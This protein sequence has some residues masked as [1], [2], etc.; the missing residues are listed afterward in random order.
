[1]SEPSFKRTLN[2]HGVKSSCDQWRTVNGRHFSHWTSDGVEEA[3]VALR[4][5][6][7]RC[8][9]FGGELYVD[10]DDLAKAAKGPTP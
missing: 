7:V 8:R 6:G 9:R 10:Q 2:Q 5:A 4:K 3:A 1:M